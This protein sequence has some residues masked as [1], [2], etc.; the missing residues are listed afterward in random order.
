LPVVRIDGRD[1]GDGGPGP[2][3]REIMGRFAAL[4]ETEAEALF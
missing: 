2:K 1:V 3:T 4:V